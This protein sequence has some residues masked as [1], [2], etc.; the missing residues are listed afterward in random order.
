[1]RVGFFLPPLGNGP[2]GSRA[3]CG[4][5]AR[6]GEK[7]AARRIF[8]C[9]M[10]RISL[11]SGEPCTAVPRKGRRRGLLPKNSGPER[12]RAFFHFR[13]KEAKDNN[14]EKFSPVDFPATVDSFG[15]G[16]RVRGAGHGHGQRPGLYVQWNAYGAGGA[17]GISVL[18]VPGQPGKGRPGNGRRRALPADDGLAEKDA[19]AGRRLLRSGAGRRQRPAADRHRAGHVRRKSRVYHG[20]VHSFCA[21]GRTADLPQKAALAALARGAFKRDGALPSV[22]EGGR[23]ADAGGRRRHAASVRRGVYRPYSYH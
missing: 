10:R 5:L 8:A 21:A 17:G 18:P 12:F 22:H 20:H 23:G 13:V 2:R 16:L 15:V 11:Y 1:M 4:F 7:Q 3:W 14:E 9:G 6:S 19:A